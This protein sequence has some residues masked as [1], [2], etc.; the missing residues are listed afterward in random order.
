MEQQ[1]SMWISFF[2]SSYKSLIRSKP[3]HRWIKS[4]GWNRAR[5]KKNTKRICEK[6]KQLTAYKFKDGLSMTAKLF[7]IQE[8]NSLFPFNIFFLN[9]TNVS[10]AFHSSDFKVHPQLF[11]YALTNHVTEWVQLM[12]ANI[13]MT[14]ITWDELCATHFPYRKDRYVLV[15]VSFYFCIVSISVLAFLI[16]RTM[17]WSDTIHTLWIKW[18][19]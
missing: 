7:E 8:F 13:Q 1:S 9:H 19:R 3:I 6:I 17:Q 15:V 14:I 12:K 18:S 16:H 2:S 4:S 5:Q 10:H 11:L